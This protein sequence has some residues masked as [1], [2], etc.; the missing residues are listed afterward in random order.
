MKK[1]AFT[2][3]EL[4]TVIVIIGLLVGLLL[5]ILSSIRETAKKTA[6][7][8]TVNAFN[9]ALTMHYNEYGFPPNKAAS[10]YT[11]DKVLTATELE[12]LL[13]MLEGG[14]VALDVSVSP[15]GNPKHIRFLSL[16]EKDKALVNGVYSIGTGANLTNSVNPWGR[17]IMAAFDYDG[18]GNVDLPD[19]SSFG[20]YAMTYTVKGACAVWTI[21]GKKADTVISSWR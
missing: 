2:L 5:P 9:I 18:D 13:A 10:P 15:G 11:I 21:G 19:N 20:P 8:A 7:A 16:N 4:L 14:D 6:S 1:K 12:R 17:S 3:V